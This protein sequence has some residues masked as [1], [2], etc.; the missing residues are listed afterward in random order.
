MRPKEVE[1]VSPR[2]WIA[3]SGFV[4]LK[5]GSP[6]GEDDVELPFLLLPSPKC[7]NYRL[8][9]L[10]APKQCH[11]VWAQRCQLFLY[12]RLLYPANH[13]WP[14]QGQSSPPSIRHSSHLACEIPA[15]TSFI[16]ELVSLVPAAS[17]PHC[18]SLPQVSYYA[19]LSAAGPHTGPSRQT[20]VLCVCVCVPVMGMRV[21][22]ELSTTEPSL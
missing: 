8:V 3:L 19:T 4:V 18:E 9:P 6:V 10:C 12:S 14:S 2:S 11:L 22:G 13:L 16:V 21:C 20:V 7:W 17:C 1:P 15:A 5:T